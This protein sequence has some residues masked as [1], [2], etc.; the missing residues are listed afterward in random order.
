MEF[1][2]FTFV[3]FAAVALIPIIGVIVGYARLQSKVDRVDRDVA[4]TNRRFEAY[5]AGRSARTKNLWDRINDV[6]NHTEELFAQLSKDLH[7]GFEKTVEGQQSL[8]H[9]ITD[10]SVRVAKLEG[11]EKERSHKNE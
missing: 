10:V 3:E 7:L 2:F 11:I 9:E 5:E 6:D 8:M 4:E 1:N